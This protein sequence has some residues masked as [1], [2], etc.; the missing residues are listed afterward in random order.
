[1]LELRTDFIARPEQAQTVNCQLIIR[2]EL[3]ALPYQE[4]YQRVR[5]EADENPALELEIGPMPA[6]VPTRLAE[7]P[8]GGGRG[9]E[10]DGWQDPTLRAPAQ[11]TLRDELRRLAGCSLTG[12]RRRIVGYLIES[13][14]ERGYLET[15]AL[16]ASFALQVSEAEAEEAI[17][18]LQQIA[19]SGVG[20]R[21][22]RECLLLQLDAVEYEPPHVRALVEQCVDAAGAG[23]WAAVASRAGLDPEQVRSALA[24][25]R[26]NL[27]PYPGESFRPSWDHL[28]PDNIQAG[29]PDA[30]IR[31]MRSVCGGD[32]TLEVTLTTS[33][34]IHLRVSEAYRRLDE[35]M[36]AMNQ[37]AGDEATTRAR[38]QVRAAR[39]L[40]WSLQQRERSLYRITCA[41]VGQQEEFI[42]EGPLALQP[43]THK[44]ISAMTGLHEST[45]SRAVAGKLAMLPSGECVP[46]SIFFDD[47]LPARTVIKGLIAAEPPEAP[48][49]DEQLQGLMAQRGYRLARRTINKYR[50]ALGIPPAAQRKADR[51]LAS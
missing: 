23:G 25:I 48:L 51:A 39:Q 10:G 17:A 5:Q 49:T 1:M 6:E 30:I 43:L 8:G 22:L 35:S 26:G 41:I 27:R 20:A 40:V 33:R 19:P 42:L 11:Y 28:L 46:Y 7:A 50:H 2:S 3:L 24:F 13:I 16:D 32:G 21:D 29:E 12:E 4:L 14:D 37:R 31:R 47:A 15:T 36:R 44:Q 45:V 34:T 9:Y 38:A 18:A